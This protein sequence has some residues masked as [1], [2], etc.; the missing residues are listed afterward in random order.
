MQTRIQD[1]R[2]QIRVFDHKSNKLT[3]ARVRVADRTTQRPVDIAF[4]KMSGYYEATKFVPHAEYTITVD[5]PT[6]QSQ[7][8]EVAIGGA[9]GSET[10]VLGEKEMPFFYRGTVKV[11]F[12][13]RPNLIGVVIRDAAPDTRRKWMTS[14]RQVARELSLTA[15][16]VHQDVT[17][18]GFF[19]FDMNGQPAETVQ[20]RLRSLEYVETVAPVLKLSEKHVTLL[21][22]RLIVKFRNTID[23]KQVPDIARQYQLQ[24][25]RNLPYAGNTFELRFNGHI[26]YSLLDICDRLVRQGLVDYAEP[27]THSTVENDL[28]TPTD[29]LYP[30]KWD[31]PIIRMPEAWQVLQDIGVNR[32]FGDPNVMIA[33]VDSGVDASHPEFSGTLTDGSSK[34][35]QLFD[36]G[37]MVANNSAIGVTDTHGT[38]CASAAAG[39]ANNAS[40]LAGVNEGNSGIAGN[41]KVM[42]IRRSGSELRFADMYV[43]IAGFNPNSSF[44][45]FPATLSRGADVITNSFGVSVGMPISG[46]MKDTFDFLTTYGRGGKGVLLFFSIGNVN[47][48]FDFTL[49]RPWAAYERTFAIGA[50]SLDNDG[51]TEVIANYSCFGP[52]IDFCAPSHD[53]YVGS[54]PQHNP[55]LNYGAITATIRSGTD[56]NA[57]GRP[58]ITTSIAANANAGFT[59]LTIGSVAGVAVGQAVLIRNPGTNQTEAKRI[60]AINAATN[61]ITV[62]PALFNNQPS[63]TPAFISSADYT[64]NFGGTS[65]ATPV[66]AGLGALVL[67]ANANLTWVEV[68]EIIRS[69]AVKLDTGNTNP[70]HRWVDIAGR[71]ATD[72]LYAGPNF[73]QLY[74][75]GRI[76]VAAAVEAARDYDFRRDIHIRDNMADTGLAPSTGTFWNGVDIWVRN[77]SP[78]TDPNPLPASYATDANT[79][80]QDVLAGQDN[81]VYARFR[82]IGTRPTYPFRVRIYLTHFGGSQFLYPTNFIPTTRPSDPIP[83]PLVPGT[84]LIGES[85]VS[86]LAAGT[87]G[88]VNVRWNSALIPPK[89]V[90]I[91]GTEVFWHPCLLVEITPHDGF[92]P[93]SG[94]IWDNNNLA[95][96]NLRIVYPDDAD[97]GKALAWA[98]VVGN[99]RNRAKF[100]TVVIRQNTAI[101]VNRYIR[102]LN[103]TAVEFITQ[104]IRSGE[105]K[106]LKPGQYNQEPVFWLENRKEVRIRF[107][108]IGAIPFIV[109][110]DKGIRVQEDYQLDVT[111]LSDNDRPAGGL[112]L[113]LSATKR[114]R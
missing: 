12:E 94:F 111:E 65:Y 25:V 100:T 72:P 14:L 45:G 22:N 70:Q 20:K 109:G 27:D 88:A 68:R 79:V 113:L 83:S 75:Y 44:A 19:V 36:F 40:V 71:I 17:N 42:G 90:L 104:G 47:N 89:K 77:T 74:G 108:N 8:R 84:Y 39:Q 58:T 24:V 32:T 95:Q 66:C 76:D 73:S 110:T 16:R 114:P 69:T 87:D 3:D 51:T 60:T 5:H 33:V 31:H 112:S 107:R 63:G 46:L 103:R 56:A 64:T 29:W 50:T 4:N 34:V 48:N 99:L 53:A 93:P 61:Q 52:M 81:W 49:N 96:K 26:D 78:A 35:F 23:V 15:V 80:H 102:F 41:C 10:F 92:T 67:S 38:C 54:A 9:G 98:G 37:S 43:W 55:P 106:G 91:G 85:S 62:S 6:L 11:P 97:S 13:P 105:L 82:N 86:S 101:P 30:S 2:I 18:N 59:N 1:P 28:V 7:Q 21:T 57:P